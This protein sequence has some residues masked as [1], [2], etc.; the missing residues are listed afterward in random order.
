MNEDDRG[1]LLARILNATAKF[2]ESGS[3][4][5]ADTGLDRIARIASPYGDAM[6]RVATYISVGLASQMLKNL[7]GVAYVITSHAIAE[8]TQGEGVMHVIDLSS[9]D[10]ALWI[11]LMH[12]LKERQQKNSH[13][14][15]P[16]VLKITGINE[17]REALDQMEI[18]LRAEAKKLNFNLHF[19]F[20][21]VVS[22]L[23]S[24]DIE[25]L[26]VIKGESL[27]IS[28]VLKLHS[29]LATDDDAML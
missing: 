10:S 13:H 16:L 7:H 8:A 15:H 12:R 9:S 22:N 26:N 23:E 3:I 17:N 6:Q 27:A 2:I 18:D 5:N 21:S 14:H 24:L 11:H 29:L 25:G 19:Q 1:K 28:S 20:N 4:M